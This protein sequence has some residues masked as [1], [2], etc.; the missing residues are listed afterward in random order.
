[1]AT[2][3]QRVAVF[4][5]SHTLGIGTPDRR[6]WA[7]MLHERYDA[8]NR[9]VEQGA[10]DPRIFDELGAY[11]MHASHL[12]TI[13]GPEIDLRFWLPNEKD[14]YDPTKRLAVIMIGGNESW[15]QTRTGKSRVSPDEFRQRATHIA[16]TLVGRSRVLYVGTLPP[17]EEKCQTFWNTPTP[18]QLASRIEF[19]KIGI[20]V[21]SK[22]GARVVPLAADAAAS[23]EFMGSITQDGAHVNTPGELWIYSRVLPTFEEMV[24]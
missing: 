2:H 9:D 16:R 5:P 14:D 19:E 13:I 15:V 23:Q 8:L 4:G 6:G 10:R 20:E 18:P 22:I 17:D 12:E 7:Q 24:R 21:F 1:M 3:V 11:A